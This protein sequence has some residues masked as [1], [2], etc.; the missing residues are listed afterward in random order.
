M[1]WMSIIL[2]LSVVSII[3]AAFHNYVKL[4]GVSPELLLVGVL[5]FALNSDRERGA[6][7][8]LI[9]GIL[10]IA[11]SGAHPLVLLIYASIGY[12]AGFY[13]EALYRQLFSAQMILALAAVICSNIVYDF[14]IS[15]MGLPYYKTIFFIAIPSAFYTAAL[16]PVIFM[17]FET[18]LPPREIEY[19]EI[20]FKKRVF[21]G[22]RPQ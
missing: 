17:A 8:G 3:E 7:S 18:V 1:S 6:V 21:E 19:K 16:A 13:K 9:G 11:V 14:V 2:S 5:Y 12:A 4:L 10:K 20:I 22:R 15:S